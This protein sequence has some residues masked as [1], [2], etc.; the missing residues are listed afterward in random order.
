MCCVS[1]VVSCSNSWYA[2]NQKNCTF[3]EIMLLVRTWEAI[4]GLDDLWAVLI[5]SGNF[6]FSDLSQPSHVKQL[7]SWERSHLQNHSARLNDFPNFPLRPGDMFPHFP[8]GYAPTHDLRHLSTPKK[9]HTLP[10]FEAI[11]SSSNHFPEAS[12]SWKFRIR[13]L[14]KEI[15]RRIHEALR[16]WA[17]PRNMKNRET[18][19]FCTPSGGIKFNLVESDEQN[20]QNIP[21]CSMGLAYLPTFG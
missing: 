4:Y 14:L 5:A 9:N 18:S 15:G 21:K 11:P 17:F 8:G 20:A 12:G 10:Y 7:T 19:T 13:R 3:S 2:T 6:Q 1:H 16:T